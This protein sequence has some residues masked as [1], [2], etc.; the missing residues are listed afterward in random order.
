MEEI[1]YLN[2]S[3]VPRSQAMVSVFDYGFLYGYGL[4]ET[5][6][7]YH[8]KLFLLERHI[9]RLLGAVEI[10]GLGQ[11]L[12]GIDLVK[13]CLETLRANGLEEARLRLTV[14]GGEADSLPWVRCDDKPTVVVTARS[15]TPFSKEKYA[16]GFKAIV[17]SQRRCRQSLVSRIKS[18]SY[19]VSVLTRMEAKEAGM[20]EALLLNDRGLVV[21]GSG[22]NVFFVK[23]SRLVT[24]SLESGILPGITRQV[25]IELAHKAGID[26]IEGDVNLADLEK[27]DEAF[28]TN[29]MIELMPLVAVRDERGKTFIIGSGRPSKI[30][31]QLMSA[32]G[33]MVG[34]ETG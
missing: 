33:E 16:E 22:S 28:M 8:G 17:A 27:A 15:F 7:A 9:K 10:I 19:L 32:Y 3:L 23:S 26:V 4:F 12:T 18:T 25:V 6:R 13:A 31:R 20:D 5:M 2:G 21:E 14:T 29:V 11:S 1:I 24:P 30:T 34:I